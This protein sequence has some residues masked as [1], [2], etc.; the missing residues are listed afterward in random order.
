MLYKKEYQLFQQQQ[1][2]KL[3]ESQYKE[4]INSLKQQ[5]IPSYIQDLKNHGKTLIFSNTSFEFVQDGSVKKIV[6]TKY[7]PIDSSNAHNFAEK[8]GVILQRQGE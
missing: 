5:D 2:Q 3:K 8:T 6:F 1:E 7:Y 4:K